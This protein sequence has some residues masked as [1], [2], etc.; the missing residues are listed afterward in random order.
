[1]KHKE[2]FSVS[3]KDKIKKADTVTG[4]WVNTNLKSHVKS[5]KALIGR[6]QPG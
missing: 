4:Y 1:M 2:K 3:A 5:A 6:N